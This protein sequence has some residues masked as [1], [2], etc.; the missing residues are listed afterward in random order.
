MHD[1]HYLTIGAVASRCG[2]PPWQVRRLFERGLLPPAPRVGAY[3]VIAAA[4]LPLVE[5]ALRDA[6]YL[7]QEKGVEHVS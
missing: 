3:R 5:K 6:G 2:C 4:D 7:P 1:P